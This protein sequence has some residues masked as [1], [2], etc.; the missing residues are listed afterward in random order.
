MNDGARNARTDLA[1]PAWPALFRDRHVHV[2]CLVQMIGEVARET[3]DDL[4]NA[5]CAVPLSVGLW[6]GFNFVI[7]ADGYTRMPIRRLTIVIGSPAETPLEEDGGPVFRAFMPRYIRR[8]E[9]AGWLVPGEW[10]YRHPKRAKAGR[11]LE[12][13]SVHYLPG[14][15]YDSRTFLKVRLSRECE[16][17]EEVLLKDF[18]LVLER[19]HLTTDWERYKDETRLVDL[20]FDIQDFISLNHVLGSL[21]ER[22]PREEALLGEITESYLAHTRDAP[23]LCRFLE[24]VVAS[25]W[26]ENVVWAVARAAY[27]IRRYERPFSISRDLLVR[28]LPAGLLMP[29]KRHLR[30]YHEAIGRLRPEGQTGE[31][32]RLPSHGART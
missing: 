24:R 2:G 15:D 31:N 9:E 18:L 8:L 14:H 3:E 26:I 22:T 1:P 5:G 13:S 11:L 12:L 23:T 7:A 28:P 27:G 16:N 6:G 20:R 29:V 19:L 17:Y 4:R 32:E 30:D 25:Q 10:E 21:Y